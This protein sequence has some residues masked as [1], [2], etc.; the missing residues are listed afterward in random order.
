M[1]NLVNYLYSPG[2]GGVYNSTRRGEQGLFRSTP[3][4]SS[5]RSPFESTPVK[6]SVRGVLESTPVSRVKGG[7][8]S[9][10]KL[11]L[12][13]ALNQPNLETKP[14]LKT[15]PNRETKPYSYQNNPKETP[16]S[17][18]QHK[19]ERRNKLYQSLSYSVQPV[20][21]RLSPS[22]R[23][24]RTIKTRNSSVPILSCIKSNPEKISRSR[25]LPLEPC[26]TYNPEQRRGFSQSFREASTSTRRNKPEKRPSFALNR[27]LQDLSPM[28]PPILPELHHS[29]L[30][31]LGEETFTLNLE[32]CSPRRPKTR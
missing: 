11:T 1:N 20:E 22:C 14:N 2:V 5:L 27:F 12:E 19:F 16:V 9:L 15:K 29:A 17:F 10:R 3:V 7:R 4:S 32:P 24:R 13:Q 30:V 26:S 23:P 21:N 31:E 28:V 18:V 8:Q 6:S 25:T